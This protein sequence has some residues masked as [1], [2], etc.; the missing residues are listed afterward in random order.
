M[1]ADD[2]EFSV[3]KR[4][5]Y[6]D[7]RA[8]CDICKKLIEDVTKGYYV[9]AFAHINCDYDCC[10]DCYKGKKPMKVGIT[11]DK[12]DILKFKT[13]SRKRAPF[14][15]SP[16]IKCNICIKDINI[17]LK[18]YYVCKNAKI[19]CDY[20][21]CVDCFKGKKEPRHGYTCD[22]ADDLYFSKN[23]RQRAPYN[24][25]IGAVCSVCNGKIKDVRK[26]YFICKN[27]ETTCSFDCCRN[28]YR[29]EKQI[30]FNFK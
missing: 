27:A 11:C 12:G 8:I 19:D 25:S 14:D 21:I 28:C 13:I 16:L 17:T 1:K 9:C 7:N 24:G 30:A 15:S 3:F 29:G 4:E 20:S 6:P 5:S 10:I 22:D 23:P 26:G 2:L 18:G